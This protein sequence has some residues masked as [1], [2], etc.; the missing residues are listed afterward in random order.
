MNE[1][2]SIK[3]GTKCTFS[4]CKYVS[5]TQKGTKSIITN[6]V[7]LIAPFCTCVKWVKKNI[8]EV[9]TRLQ[10]ANLLLIISH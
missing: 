3:F 4:H 8:R 6:K 1:K 7:S 2:K 10:V 5:V 9:H